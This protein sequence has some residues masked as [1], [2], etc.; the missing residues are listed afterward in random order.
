MKRALLIA[1]LV[2]SCALPSG[3]SSPT[4]PEPCS[5]PAEEPS[6]L[7]ISG[8]ATWFDATR[9]GQTSWYTRK[10]IIFYAAAGPALRKALGGYR[11]RQTFQIRITNPATGGYAVAIVADWCECSK[12]QKDERVIDLSPALFAALGVPLSRGV[13]RVEIEIMRGAR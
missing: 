7:L 11:W 6:S 3:L 9:N 12:G 13:Q 5:S 8:I 4:P 2:L 10:G 1:A